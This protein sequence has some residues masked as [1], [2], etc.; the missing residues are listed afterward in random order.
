MSSCSRG[1]CPLDFE[2]EL[3]PDFPP[4]HRLVIQT[5]C[6]V[7][8]QFPEIVGRRVG[9]TQI[10]ERKLCCPFRATSAGRTAQPRIRLL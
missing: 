8:A 1:I 4:T 3:S 7:G 2:D 9:E 10:A 5:L 6:S